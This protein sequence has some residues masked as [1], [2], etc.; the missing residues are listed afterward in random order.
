MASDI[1]LVFYFSTITMV[2][3]PINIRLSRMFEVR[4]QKFT[5][6]GRVVHDVMFH[7]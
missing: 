4:K 6:A 2:H 7:N 1:K 3:G 5:R